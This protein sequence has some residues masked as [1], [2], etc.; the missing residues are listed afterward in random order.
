MLLR[1]RKA[2]TKK[3]I[4]LYGTIFLTVLFIGS[5][6]L[7]KLNHEFYLQILTVLF[8]QDN[9]ISNPS[10]AMLQVSNCLFFCIPVWLLVT[11]LLPQTF[12]KEVNFFKRNLHPVEKI[13]VLIILFLIALFF[14]NTIF[15]V[16]NGLYMEDG[17]F[18]VMTEILAISASILF[19]STIRKHNSRKAK[20]IYIIL[21]ICFFLFGIQFPKWL[22]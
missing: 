22:K 9:H 7:S 21:A 20:S 19:I 13:E 8:S 18:E 2:T 17:L 4:L 6:F 16:I 5:I 1:Q 12:F 14:L 10:A 3:L 11:T 15:R